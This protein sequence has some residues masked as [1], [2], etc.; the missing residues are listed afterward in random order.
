MK[1]TR[2]Q[3]FHRMIQLHHNYHCYMLHWLR[4]RR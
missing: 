4:K 2:F 3:L 1:T